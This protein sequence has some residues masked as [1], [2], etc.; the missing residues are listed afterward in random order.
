MQFNRAYEEGKNYPVLWLDRSDVEEVQSVFIAN[1]DGSL[2]VLSLD[3]LKGWAANVIVD[4]LSYP[5]DA[6]LDMSG[7][8]SSLIMNKPGTRDWV[9]VSPEID[10]NGQQLLIRY[11]VG[12]ATV[13][14]SHR[15]E[16]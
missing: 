2:A 14:D 7:A 3:G 1:Q 13:C 11:A 10:L 4:H 12:T 6:P 5:E 9:P 8:F 16:F 15:L